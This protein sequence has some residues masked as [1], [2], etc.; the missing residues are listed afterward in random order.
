MSVRIVPGLKAGVSLQQACGLMAQ[1]FTLVGIEDAKTDARILAA[2]AL[3]LSRAQLISQSDRELE[4][5]EADALSARAARRLKREPVSRILGEREFWGL[6]FAI[7]S[8]VLDP[9]PETETLVE[10]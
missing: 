8:A 3:K 4:P 10:T 1:A 6:R 5:R 7:N 2:H 9:R